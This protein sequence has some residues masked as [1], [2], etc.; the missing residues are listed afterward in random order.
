MLTVR[1]SSSHIWDSIVQ[2]FLYSSI[3]KKNTVA[4]DNVLRTMLASGSTMMKKIC[5][6]HSRNF[7]SSK[8]DGKVN[9]Q[10]QYSVM[11]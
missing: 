3:K 11:S 9:S 10:A 8:K 2:K 5:S 6:L 7:A 1:G 4:F